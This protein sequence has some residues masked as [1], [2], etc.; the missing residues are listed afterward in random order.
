MLAAI[1]RRPE[2]DGAFTSSILALILLLSPV[3][4][5]F[6][7]PRHS[8]H[9]KPSASSSFSNAYLLSS[10]SSSIILFEIAKG[11]SFVIRN[12]QHLFYINRRKLDKL[13]FFEETLPIK[14][15]Y[16]SYWK[17]N[18]RWKVAWSRFWSTL[19]S[20]AIVPR[21][22]SPHFLWNSYCAI[23]IFKHVRSIIIISLSILPDALNL[24]NNC[25]DM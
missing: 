14:S 21:I 15:G 7:L 17:S 18:K 3:T 1:I 6:F 20:H 16:V 8:F 4:R 24:W 25:H 23:I 10:S 2:S 11:I 9:C 5:P 22:R 19:V 13:D 12:K